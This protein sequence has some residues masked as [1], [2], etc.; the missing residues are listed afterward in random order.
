[1]VTH[2][3]YKDD[4]G[5]WL[6]PEEVR[7]LEGG[8]SVH[9]QTGRPVTV[10]RIEVMSKS[11][12]NVVAPSAIIDSYGADTARLFILSD[13]P[14]ERDLQWTE[15]GVE[16]AWTYLNRVY[17]LTS[18]RRWNC[19]WP[20]RRCRTGLPEGQI[21]ASHKATR[22]DR[23]SGRA[24]LQRFVA[25]IAPSRTSGDTRGRGLAARSL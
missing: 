6:Y 23:E 20:A 17:R 15:A 10:G 14:P 13:S 9:H 21:R 11:K 4:Q 24:A 25:L 5:K 7:R 19:R 16:G 12:K 22:G 2:E 3:S 1:M 8:A 18:K